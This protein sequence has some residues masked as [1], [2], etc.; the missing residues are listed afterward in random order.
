MIRELVEF[1]IDQAIT[2]G[3]LSADVYRTF[4]VMMS[5]ISV[6]DADKVCGAL[7]K[8]TATLGDAAAQGWIDS[9]KAGEVYRFL[10]QQ[11]GVDLNPGNERLDAINAAEALSAE[12][13]AILSDIA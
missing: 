6:V 5:T 8:L 4:D 2:A 1:V 9:D 12:A 13:R 11:I 3:T 7:Q 10:L